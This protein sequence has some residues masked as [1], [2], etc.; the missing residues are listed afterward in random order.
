MNLHPLKAACTAVAPPWSIDDIHVWWSKLRHYIPRVEAF[1][2]SS[3]GQPYSSHLYK[4]LNYQMEPS[5]FLHYGL[6]PAQK[7]R[8]SVVGRIHFSSQALFFLLPLYSIHLFVQIHEVYFGKQIIV[9]I[10]MW[11]KC[12]SR[13]SYEDLALFERKYL[14]T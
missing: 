12:A 13:C 14:I 6:A 3:R 7:I 8:S 2:L 1:L 10:W 4:R 5:F 9:T 11:K